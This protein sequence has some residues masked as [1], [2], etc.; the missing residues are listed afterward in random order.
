MEDVDSRAKSYVDLLTDLSA[1]EST[2]NFNWW[3]ALHG[4]WLGSPPNQHLP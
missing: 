1:T 4:L 3:Q 2:N